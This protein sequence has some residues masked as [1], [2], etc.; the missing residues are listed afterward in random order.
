MSSTNKPSH[1]YLPLQ[2]RLATYF[3]Y[4]LV[5]FGW[6]NIFLA[7]IFGDPFALLGVYAAIWLVLFQV[8]YGFFVGLRFKSAWHLRWAKVGLV[9]LLLVIALLLLLATLSAIVA[10]IVCLIIFLIAVPAIFS[11][12]Y[13]LNQVRYIP[14][15]QPP[16]AN[17]DANLLDD[18]FLNTL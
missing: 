15:Q 8:G 10:L 11:T 9:Y 17:S 18:D 2:L 5:F 12:W 6:G 16:V 13:A 14:T 1:A 7:I 4:L 3:Q